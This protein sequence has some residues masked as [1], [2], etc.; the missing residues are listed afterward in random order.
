MEKRGRGKERERERDTWD[1]IYPQ[2]PTSSLGPYILID[3]YSYHEVWHLFDP[4]TS[5]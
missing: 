2:W 1:K 5:W 3:N 4:I